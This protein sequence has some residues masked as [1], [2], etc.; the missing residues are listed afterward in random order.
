M[1]RIWCLEPL[2][3]PKLGRSEED[4]RREVHLPEPRKSMFVILPQFEFPTLIGPP[5]HS[6][7]TSGEITNS[8]VTCTA[9]R[10]LVAI[11]RSALSSKA[12]TTRRQ[13]G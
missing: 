2:S 10:R 9:I 5:R 11:P 7:F 13:P 6:I 1:E 3:G 8:A 4:V 12:Y